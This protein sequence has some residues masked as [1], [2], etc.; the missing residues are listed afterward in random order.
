MSQS[1]HPE[2]ASFLPDDEEVIRVVT[3]RPYL[4]SLF[5][6]RKCYLTQRRILRMDKTLGAKSFREIPL[7]NVVA[8]TQG[9]LFKFGWFAL[10]V[11]LLVLSLVLFATDTS[12]VATFV[13][14]VSIAIFAAT[15]YTRRSYFRLHTTNPNSDIKIP[16]T[17]STGRGK[18]FE[19]FIQYTRHVWNKRNQW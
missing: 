17:R 19:E 2:I 10:G 1:E 8:V 12:D 4:F 9:R 3:W 16:L 14:L 18:P 6:R 15:L 5:T 7:K 13:L 11:A